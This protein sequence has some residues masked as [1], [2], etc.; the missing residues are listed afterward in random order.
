MDGISLSRE[1]RSRERL[2][3]KDYNRLD[4]E[5][6]DS[7]PEQIVRQLRQIQ[8]QQLDL[9]NDLISG[10]EEPIPPSPSIKLAQHIVQQGETLFLVARKYNTTV[11]NILRVNPD[12]KDPDEIQT[13]MVINLP[14]LLPQKPACY[15]E[16]TVNA[17]D[18]LFKLA[19]RFNTTVNELV[20]YNSIKDPDLIYPGRILIIPCSDNEGKSREE[21]EGDIGGVKENSI[22][23]EL[24]FDTLAKDNKNSFDRIIKE[25]LFTANTRFRLERILDNLGIRI[26]DRVDFEEDIVIG[27]VEYNI[28]ELKLEDRV[29]KIVVDSKSKGYHL[30]TVSKKKFSFEG[31]YKI[32]F[33]T[34]EDKRLYQDRINI[35]F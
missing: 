11:A 1:I 31:S 13:G 16:Y 25:S 32:N 30:I 20:Y 26:S 7:N 24:C 6:T 18:T 17:G 29:I 8:N 10:L 23:G 5:V 34:F 19:Q 2:L 9:L 14:V 27:A 4:Q 28:E 22:K 15:F 35:S 33:V 12:I 3:K 21:Y